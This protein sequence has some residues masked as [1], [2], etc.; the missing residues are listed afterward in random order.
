MIYSVRIWNDDLGIYLD[1]MTLWAMENCSSFHL[2]YSEDYSDTNSGSL[3]ADTLYV[4]QFKNE[5]DAVFF[6]LKWK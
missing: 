6:A 3:P 4:F 2:N 5:S 1:E